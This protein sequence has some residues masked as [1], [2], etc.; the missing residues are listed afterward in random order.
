MIL[1]PTHQIDLEDEPSHP[2]KPSALMKDLFGEFVGSL[3]L[4]R[5]KQHESSVA[6]EDYL[7]LNILFASQTVSIASYSASGNAP[8][9]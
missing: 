2:P 1:N 6:K 4:K 3:V 8:M 5:E 7:A 9:V